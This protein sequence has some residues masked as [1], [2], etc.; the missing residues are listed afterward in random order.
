MAAS[1]SSTL[2]SP[3]PSRV[4]QFFALTKP[5]VVQLIVFCAVIGML[6]AVPASAGCQSGRPGTASSM[7]ITA[8]KTISCTTRGLVS[9]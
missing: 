5:R 2:V 4:A 8:Q 7:P 9:A 1:S 3:A 6:L